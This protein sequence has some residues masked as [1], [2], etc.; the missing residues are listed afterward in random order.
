MAPVLFTAAILA[1][2]PLTILIVQGDWK[3]AAGVA[4][5]VFI[6]FG[7]LIP[8][9]LLILAALLSFLGANMPILN[10]DSVLTQFRWAMLLA[11]ALA[12]LLRSTAQTS[13]A[14]W[15]AVHFSLILFAIYAAISSF[16]SVSSLLTILKATAFGCLLVASIL[17][18]RLEC[19][20]A[21]ESSCKLLEQF[22]W[23]TVLAGLGCLLTV[24]HLLPPSPGYFEG[25]FQNPNSWGAFIPLIAPVVLFKCVRPSGKVPFASSC[26]SRAHS[27]LLRVFAHVEIK[28]RYDSH[29]CGV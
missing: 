29:L 26:E 24:V 4:G 12:F 14:R 17:Y 20:H 16:Y 9:D 21:P 2:L 11:M 10:L 6:L 28:D 13:P 7:S 27:S 25:P 15:H 18:G 23:C 19:R 5:V 1:L 22:Y 8:P 3:F